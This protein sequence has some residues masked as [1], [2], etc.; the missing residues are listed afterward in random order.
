MGQIGIIGSQEFYKRLIE[1]NTQITLDILMEVAHETGDTFHTDIIQCDEVYQT[2]TSDIKRPHRSTYRWFINVHTG[3]LSLSNWTIAHVETSTGTQAKWHSVYLY[4][5]AAR[6][7]D[8]RELHVYKL[9]ELDP[10]E[11]THVTFSSIEIPTLEAYREV[12]FH[13]DPVHALS[14][15]YRDAA[16]ERLDTQLEEW[17]VDEQPVR[18]ETERI[19]QTAMRLL[20]W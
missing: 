20:D 17:M 4:Y 18:E 3:M 13:P 1:A 10:G 2:Y 19:N 16:F 12:S 5:I 14:Y 7:E 9:K 11:P 8:I 6:T 15:E